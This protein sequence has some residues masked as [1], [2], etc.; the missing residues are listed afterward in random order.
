MS[1]FAG[2]SSLR[3]W[4]IPTVVK[5]ANGGPGII[6]TCV[7]NTEKGKIPL[8]LILGSSLRVWGIRENICFLNGTDRIIPT[9]VGNTNPTGASPKSIE[10]HPYVCGEYS[11]FKTAMAIEQ[12]SSLRVWGIH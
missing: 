9:C 8:V 10:D 11:H 1:G 5:V 2:G 6:P 7:G 3:V 12:G 4:G